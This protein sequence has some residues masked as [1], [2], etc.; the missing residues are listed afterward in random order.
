MKRPPGVTI[1]GLLY[2][3]AGGGALLTP[4]DRPL[5]SFGII[6]RGMMALCLRTGASL[7]GVYLGYGLLKLFRHTWYLYFIAACLGTLSLSLNVWRP[8]W[9]AERL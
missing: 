5:L 3:F 6:H 8:E 7:L 1:L 2:I 4:L 9:N